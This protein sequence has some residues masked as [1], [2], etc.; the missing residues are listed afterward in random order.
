MQLPMRA[1]MTVVVVLICFVSSSTV[2]PAADRAQSAGPSAGAGSRSSGPLKQ[3]VE[4]RL[5]QDRALRGV[6]VSVARNDVTLTGSVQSLWGEETRRSGV[7]STSA[8]WETW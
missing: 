3:A 4:R 8:A 7:R 2:T 1:I 6:D 5:H